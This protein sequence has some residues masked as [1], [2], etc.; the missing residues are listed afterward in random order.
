M[1]LLCLLNALFLVI[2]KLVQGQVE[3]LLVALGRCRTLPA[4][5]TPTHYTKYLGCLEGRACHCMCVRGLESIAIDS[6]FIVMLS[7][8][9]TILMVEVGGGW[10]A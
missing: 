4:S 2:E 7:C 8:Q 6:I 5:L 1:V 9:L 10:W 3:V